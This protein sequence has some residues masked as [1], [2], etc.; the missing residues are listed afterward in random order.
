MIARALKVGSRMSVERCCTDSQADTGLLWVRGS[1]GMLE[2]LEKARI[3]TE[4]LHKTTSQLNSYNGRLQGALEQ[5]KSDCNVGVSCM[6]SA[7]TALLRSSLRRPLA[8]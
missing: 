2:G 8:L 6:S 4:Q 5:L 3:Y 1:Q 7:A